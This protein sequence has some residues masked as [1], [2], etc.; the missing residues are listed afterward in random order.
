ML[1]NQK[2]VKEGSAI[3]ENAGKKKKEYD[4][5]NTIV[6]NMIN[7]L[8]ASMRFEGTLNVDLNEVAINMVPFPRKHF[9]T[10][11]LTPLY[12][13]LDSNLKPRKYMFH[14]HHSNVHRC[15]R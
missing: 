9:L 12:G 6:A 15:N 10:S 3:T 1:K 2:G 4:R 5:E 8:T 14:K 7:N 11:S 13:I